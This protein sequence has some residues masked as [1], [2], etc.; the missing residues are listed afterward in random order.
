[1]R[2]KILTNDGYMFVTFDCARIK[3]ATSEIVLEDRTIANVY[4]VIKYN[5]SECECTEIDDLATGYANFTNK[6]KYSAY[7]SGNLM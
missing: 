1:M 5:K 7:T 4:Y 3:V 2:A 6:D